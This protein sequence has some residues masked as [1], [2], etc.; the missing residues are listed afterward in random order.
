[1]K[2]W[3]AALMRCDTCKGHNR[4]ERCR[5]EEDVFSFFFKNGLKVHQVC[6]CVFYFQLKGLALLWWRFLSNDWY[7]PPWQ[8]DAKCQP[9]WVA[10]RIN[11]VMLC[12]VVLTQPSR[13]QLVNDGRYVLS[14]GVGALGLVTLKAIGSVFDWG[15]VLYW[16]PVPTKLGKACTTACRARIMFLYL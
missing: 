9:D 12:Q 15:G 14:G 13:M 5:L 6:V 10:I 4:S 7:S 11:S 3:T 2:V 16:A 8:H 1:M